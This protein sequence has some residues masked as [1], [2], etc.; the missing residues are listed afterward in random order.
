[1]IYYFT[2]TGN[3]LD[4][5]RQLLTLRK[6]QDEVVTAI[7]FTTPFPK[8]TDDITELGLVFPVYGWGPPLVVEDFIKRLPHN[9][10]NHSPYI[11]VILTC[12]DDIGCTDI[13]VRNLLAA[14][15]WKV[16]AIFSLQMR[17]TYIC[18]PGF[19]T[20]AP[21]LE[22]QKTEKA[23]TSL[24]HIVH[25]IQRHE[26]SSKK[27]VHPGAF[28]RLK[29]YILRPFFNRFLIHD[30][31][32]SVNPQKC[33]TCGK[34]IRICPLKNMQPNAAG[35]PEWLGHCTHCLRCFHACPQHAIEYGKFTQRKSQVKV[36]L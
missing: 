25:C 10:A 24:Q 7:D 16:N 13:I 14:K 19:N 32:F 30:K 1:M 29:S 3:S 12:G 31:H 36:K 15:G 35:M 28:P 20:D 18:L 5:V 11:Y 9:E 22:Q 4:V 33:T 8:F 2:G 17:N 6:K 21:L 23:R 26:S 34:C 27:D